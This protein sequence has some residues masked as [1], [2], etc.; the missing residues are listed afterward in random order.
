MDADDIR[1]TAGAGNQFTSVVIH[2][3]HHLVA[4]AAKDSSDF[5]LK[6]PN[7]VIGCSIVQKSNEAFDVIAEKIIGIEDATSI[8]IL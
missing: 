1:Q 7:V 4:I 5:I 8:P 2:I 6:V 3:A